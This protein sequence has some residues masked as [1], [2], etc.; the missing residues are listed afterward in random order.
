MEPK[1]IIGI[2]LVAF[3]IGGFIFLQIRNRRK[4]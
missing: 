1:A 2:V 4:K 3:I